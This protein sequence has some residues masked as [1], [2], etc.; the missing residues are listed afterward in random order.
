MVYR[1]HPLAGD[2]TS[3]QEE[4]EE[5][6]ANRPSQSVK[7]F[8]G[9]SIGTYADSRDLL[10]CAT[11]KRSSNCYSGNTCCAVT[12]QNL[13][14]ALACTALMRSQSTAVGQQG[15]SSEGFHHLREPLS[16]LSQ[17]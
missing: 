3:C 8:I 12:T 4:S 7:R 14:D 2:S 16:S 17:L 9:R 6:F 5:R 11:R 13:H 1:L 15:H 10:E